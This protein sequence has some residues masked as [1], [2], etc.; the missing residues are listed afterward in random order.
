MCKAAE[1]APVGA[2]CEDVVESGS[3]PDEGDLLSTRKE[4]RVIIY[5]APVGEPLLVGPVRVHQV[6]LEIACAIA[7]EG[8]LLA[9]GGERGLTVLC[10]VMGQP[11]LVGPVGVHHVDL[12]IAV[13]V[14]YEGDPLAIGGEGRTGIE[15]GIVSQAPGVA[16]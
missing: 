10:G 4:D 5:I 16:S 13:A 8:D 9:V 11:L 3:H 12:V 2:D 7:G 6:N 14:A 1:L 15:G